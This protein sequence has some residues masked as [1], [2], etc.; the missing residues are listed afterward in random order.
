MKQH[1][2]THLNI[3]RKCDI[4][5]RT[6]KDQAYI[7]QHRRGTHGRGWMALCG[8]VVDWPPKL[9]RHQKK[10]KDCKAIKEK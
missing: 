5:S 7:R 1:A 9:L 10:C 6:F 4:C 3:E 2:K 8:A